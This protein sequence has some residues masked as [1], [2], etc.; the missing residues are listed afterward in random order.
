MVNKLSVVIIQQT[1]LLTNPGINI[2]MSLMQISDPNFCHMI[3]HALQMG[4]TE[5]Q[6]FFYAAT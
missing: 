2:D 3:P 6:E 5:S 1:S 4:W